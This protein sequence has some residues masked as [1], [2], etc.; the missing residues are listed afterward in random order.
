MDNNSTP[1]STP[2]PLIQPTT[3]EQSSGEIITSLTKS[4]L[5]SNLEKSG[6]LLEAVGVKSYLDDE[7]FTK[8]IDKEGVKTILASMSAFYL[9]YQAKKHW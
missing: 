7:G 6:K 1:T 2:A 3:T 4:Y 5:D 9:M 8:G